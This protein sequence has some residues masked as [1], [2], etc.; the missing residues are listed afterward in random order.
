MFG[1]CSLKINELLETTEKETGTEVP[2]SYRCPFKGLLPTV[3]TIG[4][5]DTVRIV[6]NKVKRSKRLWQ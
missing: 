5:P 1:I 2:V 3:P 6:S 4:I